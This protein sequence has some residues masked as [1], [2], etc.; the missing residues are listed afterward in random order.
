MLSYYQYSM[1]FSYLIGASF[2]IL[3]FGGVVTSCWC[4]ITEIYEPS[5]TYFAVRI[6]K[7]PDGAITGCLMLAIILI[8]HFVLIAR[9][10]FLIC[11]YVCKRKSTFRGTPLLIQNCIAFVMAYLHPENFVKP[12]QWTTT[13]P[14]S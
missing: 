5:Y 1:W 9:G 4:K 13:K 3:R 8:V 12:R 14:C 11:C 6:K 10:L 7:P 2:T